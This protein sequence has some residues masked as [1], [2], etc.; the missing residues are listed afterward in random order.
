[1][2]TLF[3]PTFAYLATISPLTVGTAGLQQGDTVPL[4]NL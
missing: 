4:M 2:K 3:S 1:L